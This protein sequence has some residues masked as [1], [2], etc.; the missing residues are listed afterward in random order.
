MIQNI[1]LGAAPND[2]TGTKARIAGQMINANFA[3]LDGKIDNKNYLEVETGFTLLAQDLTMNANWKWVI[4]GIEYTNPVA[5][6]IP[7]PLASAGKS[8]IDLIVCNSSNTFSRITG[9]ESTFTPVAPG[10]PTNTIFA[11]FFTVS[12]GVVSAPVLPKPKAPVVSVNGMRGE[13]VLGI[14]DIPSLQSELDL[15][16]DASAY[17]QYFKGVYLTLA[18]LI[19]AHPTGVAGDTAQV[20]EI[21]A[22]DVINYSWDAEESIWVNNGTGGSGAVNTD[23]LPEG[24]SQLYFQTARVL[25]TLLTGISFVTG[26]AIVSTD[27]VLVAFGKLQKQ[28]TDLNTTANIKSLLGITTLS[29]SNTGDQELILPV[30]ETGTSFSLTDAYN[31]KVV[32]L[33]ASCTVTIP[34]GLIAG[35]EVSII[36]LAGVTLT[37][38]LGGSVV[39]FNNVGTTMAEKLSCTIKNRTLTNNYITA[40]SL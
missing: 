37:I 4:S 30:T 13:V 23:A 7:I 40:G 1:N 36:T 14:T 28:I 38:A 17:N 31:G 16:L 9:E 24:T 11:T 27:S 26:G 19:A 5:V 10:V 39:L 35:F 8:R 34:N 15:K 3:Y 21:G 29:G 32:I 25:A 6:E 20:N 12:D 18:A 2:K 33:T 22:T